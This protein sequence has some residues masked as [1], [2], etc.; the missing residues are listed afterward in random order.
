MVGKSVRVRVPEPQLTITE[1]DAVRGYA[2]AEK[3]EATRRGYRS[4]FAGFS[5]WCA[6]RGVEPLPA[7]PGT[8]AAFFAAEATAGA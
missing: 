1:A 6:N 7:S 8:V 4:D 2:L 3:S 5:C